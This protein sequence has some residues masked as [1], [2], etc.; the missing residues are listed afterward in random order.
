MCL[1]CNKLSSYSLVGIY[2]LALRFSLFR[3]PMTSDVDMPYIQFSNSFFF[4]LVQK[5]HNKLKL[6]LALPK[7]P[8]IPIVFPGNMFKKKVVGAQECACKQNLKKNT[9]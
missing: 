4:F 6:Q 2:L 7:N 9:P 8:A 5:P 1:K 3:E